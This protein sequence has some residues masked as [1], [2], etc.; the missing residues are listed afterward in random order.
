MTFIKVI[1]HKSCA[2]GQKNNTTH[3]PTKFLSTLT[4][5]LRVG[6]KKKLKKIKKRPNAHQI[7]WLVSWGGF[8]HNRQEAQEKI[9]KITVL[10]FDLLPNSCSK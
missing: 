3:I 1:E 7:N 8:P 6:E 2:G 10:H 9:I 4:Q 5:C